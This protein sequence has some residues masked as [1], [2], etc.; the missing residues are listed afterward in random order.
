M[1]PWPGQ[2]AETLRTRSLD[3]A[4]ATS[5]TREAGQRAFAVADLI[6][7]PSRGAVLNEF[8]NVWALDAELAM[9]EDTTASQLSSQL[10]RRSHIGLAAPSRRL[11]PNLTCHNP[12]K[13]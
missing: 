9:S 1:S 13:L 12:S 4:A 11:C 3:A 5:V 6:T 2:A 8:S 7:N 10:N